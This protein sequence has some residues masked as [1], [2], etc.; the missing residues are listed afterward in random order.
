MLDN[1]TG[2]YTLDFLCWLFAHG[3]MPPYTP[4]SGSY[5]NMAG[6]IQRIL[7]RRALD[8]QQPQSPQDIIDW[9]EAAARG[10]NRHPTASIWGGKR[11]A[12]R[13]RAYMPSAAR[14]PRRS[15]RY[16]DE[17]QPERMAIRMT[18]DPLVQLGAHSL[19]VSAGLRLRSHGS[20][21]ALRCGA[22]RKGI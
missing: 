16:R 17:T 8:G 9:L 15:K 14:A 10:W 7:K 19:A 5:L 21:Q 18:C 13:A 6:S 20:V 3:I 11:Q 4:L 12:R 22:S 2:H 1:L